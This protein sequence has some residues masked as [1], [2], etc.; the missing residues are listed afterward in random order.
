MGPGFPGGGQGMPGGFPGMGGP[1]G[2]GGFPG[3]GGRNGSAPGIGGG[4]AQEATYTRWVYNRD[5]NKYAFVIDKSGHVIQIEAIGLN[6]PNVHTRRGIGF[7]SN[8]A[9]VI[10]AYK[11][12]DGYE[13]AGDNIMVKYLVNDKVAFRLTRLGDK[14]PHAVTGIVIS[15]G[16]G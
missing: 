7:G 8:F 1:G 13:I 4:A 10:K 5:N 14:Q 6:N 16:K 15:A 11:N 9:S 3:Q 12:P 2:P